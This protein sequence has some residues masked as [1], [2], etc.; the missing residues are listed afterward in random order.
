M[1][2]LTNLNG[3]K[4][5]YHISRLTSYKGP[6]Y[7]QINGQKPRSG[8][9]SGSWERQSGRGIAKDMGK[10]LKILPSWFSPRPGLYG[11]HLFNLSKSCLHQPAR[12]LTSVLQCFV[13]PMLLGKG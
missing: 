1:K 12:V 13:S 6:A 10:A 11:T 4:C 9:L 5:V 8:L 7:Q 2:L 3:F